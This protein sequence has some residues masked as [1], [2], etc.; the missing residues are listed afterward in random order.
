MTITRMY[1]IPGARIA[2]SLDRASLRKFADEMG[3][4]DTPITEIDVPLLDDGDLVTISKCVGSV[5]DGDG[6]VSGG[7]WVDVTGIYREHTRRG[8]AIC[9]Q[10]V[11]SAGRHLQSIEADMRYNGFPYRN[12]RLAGQRGKE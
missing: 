10:L 1:S 3:Y 2:C 5:E 7:Q 11:D 12:V 8:Q 9:G 6:I 4:A